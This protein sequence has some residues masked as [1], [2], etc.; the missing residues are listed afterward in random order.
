[1]IKSYFGITQTP[2]SQDKNK[3]LCHQ[4]EEFEIIRVHSTLGGLCLIMG[5]PG[6]GKTVLKE[7]LQE[8][9]GKTMLVATVSRTL[10]TYV[11]TVKILCEAFKIDYCNSSFKCEKKLIEEAHNLKR[12][13]KSL[14]TII[15]DAHLMDMDTLRRLRLMFG[16]FPRNHNLVLIGQPSLLH[17]MNL[18]VN[19]D[20]KC[21]VTY[22]K[23]LKPLNPDLIKE[24]IFEELDKVKL[25]HN[26]YTEDAL[27]LIVRT[28]EGV[29]R[30]ARNLA[31]SCLLEAVR[32]QT[33]TVNLKIVNKVI[34]QP[35][36]RKEDDVM[37]T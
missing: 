2:F 3:L 11:N 35:H 9:S 19:E 28:S 5:V 34:I 25:G 7:A 26:I 37:Y 8:L 22:S 33:K 4:S 10:H 21:R 31:L 36:W 15:D 24:F 29:L 32:D 27:D 18:S 23:M 1:M 16:D 12:Q 30:K 17:Q 6:T 14:M 13:G 20:L